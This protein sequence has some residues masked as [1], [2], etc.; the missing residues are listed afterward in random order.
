[1]MEEMTIT[2]VIDA[3]VEEVWRAWTDPERVMRWWGPMGF[4]SPVAKID[5]RE[6]GKYLFSMRSPEGDTFWSTGVYR[7]IVPRKQID[8]T[9]SFA[10]E[11]G[12]VVPGSH[13]GMDA[14]PDETHVTLLFEEL[15][16]NKTRLTITQDGVP[17]GELFDASLA[18]WNE[19]LDKL[20]K[21]LLEMKERQVG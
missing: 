7:K 20:E 11:N 5:L 2:R 3:P 6:G 15:S 16:G 13:Y 18:G 4:T 9:D 17:S 12:N 10:D 8:Y 21:S 19:S 1:M 14:F